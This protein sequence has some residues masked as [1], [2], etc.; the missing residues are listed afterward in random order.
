MGAD[1]EKEIRENLRDGK[2]PCAVAWRIAERAGV[3]CRAVGEMADRLD[4]RISHCQLGLFGYG[5]K[6]LGEHKIVKQPASLDS[7][8]TDAIRAAARDGRVTCAQLFEI[9]GRLGRPPMDA[10]AHAEALGV[11]VAQCQ[12]GC[13]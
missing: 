9:A 13:F 1:L 3:E 4:I 2:L 10:S 7:A 5:E 8:L 6:R 11:K 12:L